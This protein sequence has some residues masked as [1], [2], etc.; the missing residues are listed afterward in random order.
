MSGADDDAC[1]LSMTVT[2]R[3]IAG[4]GKG[5]PSVL[6][7]QDRPGNTALDEGRLAIMRFTSKRDEVV[8][9][10]KRFASCF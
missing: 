8:H 6:C 5:D 2:L 3:I 9:D 1:G 4:P 10:G 7:D